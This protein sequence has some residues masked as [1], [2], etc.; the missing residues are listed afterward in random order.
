MKMAI[1]LRWAVV[2][3]SA[4]V[5]GAGLS[6]VTAQSGSFTDERD[7]KTYK[8]VKIGRQTWMAEN[9]NYQI[10]SDSWCYNDS[11]YYCD[12]YGKLYNWEAAMMAC[13]N[14]YH[15]P[16]RQEWDELVDYVGGDNVA[17]KMLKKRNGW[18]KNSNGTDVYGFGALPGGK[19]YNK[20][21]E[22]IWCD[23]DCEYSVFYDVGNYGGWW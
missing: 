20:S 12:K 1:M 6:P 22:P 14:G 7:G 17:S 13:P 4:V 21:M 2:A 18:N 3:A 10:D 19:R 8:T 11:N 23:D 16:T 9:L 5:V 15:L